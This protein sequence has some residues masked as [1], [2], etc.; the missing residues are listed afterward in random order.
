MKILFSTERMFVREF[1]WADWESVHAYAQLPEVSQ[2]Q[3]WGPNTALET[4]SFI[5]QTLVYQTHNPRFHYELCVCLK[6]NTH[7]GGCGIFVEPTRPKEALIGY[8]LHPKYWNQGFASEIVAYLVPYCREQLKLETIGA[9]CDTRNIA[10]QKVLEKN[11]FILT[12]IK[13][14]DFLKKGTWRHTY[15]YTLPVEEPSRKLA[16]RAG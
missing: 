8:L 5:Q 15:R 3:Y 9:T 13:E 1:Q 2:Y 16:V 12:A 10:S 6:N 14:N 11:G 7:I 4:K